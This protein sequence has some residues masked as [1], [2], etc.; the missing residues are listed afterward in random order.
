M[1]NQKDLLA[2]EKVMQKALGGL[3]TK[4]TNLDNRVAKLET[5]MT[6]LKNRVTNVETGMTE[7]KG[8]VT[9]L[10]NRMAKLETD[11]TGIKDRVTNLESNMTVVRA[12]LL[13]NNVVPRISTIE[14]CYLDTS[15]RYLEKSEKFEAAIVDIEVMKLA[16]QKNSADI[17]ELKRKQA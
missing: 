6:E 7:L 1:L 3:E 17:Q 13:E 8:Q 10:D 9:S 16:I 5:G 11:M 12:D 2:I 4:V 14:K 15:K